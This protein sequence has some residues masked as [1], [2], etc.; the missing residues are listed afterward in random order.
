[1]IGN[2]IV[3]QFMTKN[4]PPVDQSIIDA[5]LSFGWIAP[6][7]IFLMQILEIKI[8]AKDTAIPIECNRLAIRFEEYVEN[9]RTE[10]EDFSCAFQQ[11]GE[12]IEASKVCSQKIG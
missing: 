7:H 10:V 3:S 8:V 6:Q 9:I 4:D 11:V 5:R 1:M 2:Q 12:T